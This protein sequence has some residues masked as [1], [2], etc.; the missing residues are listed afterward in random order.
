M[1]RHDYALLADLF[2]YPDEGYLG[3]VMRVH[4]YLEARCPPAARAVEA[5]VELAPRGNVLALQELYTRSFD[6]QAITTL[7]IGYV[8]FGE[9]YK[10]GELLSNLMR[11]HREAGNDCGTELADHLPN[12]LRLLSKLRDEELLVEFVQEIL[13]PA[14]RQMI[15]EFDPGRMEKKDEEYR[16]HHKTLIDASLHHRIA[17]RHTLAA[18]AAVLDVDFQFVKKPLLEQTADFLTSLVTEMKIENAEETATPAA[19]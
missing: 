11:E 7:D 2:D 16:K 12:V 15:G 4:E 13:V 8:L 5:F 1:A 3:R 9:D 19:R 18:L 14:L 6:V 17:F 10:R